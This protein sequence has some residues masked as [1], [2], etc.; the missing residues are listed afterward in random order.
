MP[1]RN[2]DIKPRR[3]PAC[4]ASWMARVSV[5]PARNP[6]HHVGAALDRTQRV[7]DQVSEMSSTTPGVA[8]VISIAG[9]S[10]LDSSS[11]LANAGVGREIAR[12]FVRPDRDKRRKQLG[13]VDLAQGLVPDR[14]RNV[15]LEA[16]DPPP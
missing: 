12:A 11:S 6:L 5:A 15:I 7:L 4:P 16:R 2:H 1:T 8:Q 13:R 3:F 9:I 10:A 14:G